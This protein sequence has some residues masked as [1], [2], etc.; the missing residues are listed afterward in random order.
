MPLSHWFRP[1][2][3]LLILFLGITLVLASALGWLGWRLL[4]QDRALATQ[5]IQQRLD[6]SAD[7]ISAA[8]LRRVSVTEQMLTR[9]SVLPATDLAEEAARYADQLGDDALIV[10]LS[11]QRID[12]YPSSRLL[13]YPSLPAVEQPPATVFTRGES[14]EFRERD[15]AKAEAA[16][17]QLAR[18]RDPAIRAGAL[19][20][21]GRAL[22]KANRPEMAL[23]VYQDL[24]LLDSTPVAGLPAGLVARHARLPLLD[25]LKHNAALR[26][27]AE[28]LY[29]DLHNGRWQVTQ[30]SYEFYAQEVR[31]RISSDHVPALNVEPPE[32]PALV[33]AHG[34]QSLWEEWRSGDPLRGTSE[35]RRNLRV[36]DR[37]LLL[38]WR[39]SPERL[40]GMVAGPGYLER[41][42]ISDLDPLLTRQRVKLALTDAEGNQV[43]TQVTSESPQR[44]I[45]TSR[46]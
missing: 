20:R 6:D 39:R 9:L 27:E 31:R 10:V 43:F 34:V 18:S 5:R 11:A 13:Y 40:V 38:L 23:A 41:E 14:F 36:Q 45:R 7:L 37:P 33:L 17:R 22:R 25:Q 42:W 32:L 44:A 3:H 8:L 16:F 12:A 4:Q 2:R 19:L 35:G 46:G 15:Y 28:S 21:L 29:A 26:Q 1:P 30:A 24:A